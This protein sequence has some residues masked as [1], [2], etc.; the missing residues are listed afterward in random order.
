VALQ[1]AELLVFAGAGVSLSMPAGLPV[2]D[3]IRDEILHQLGLDSYVQPPGGA[4]DGRAAVAA[5]LVPE[6]FML[7]LS[8]AGVDVQKWLEMVL[9]AGQPNA[10]HRVLAQLTAA[11]ARVWTVNFD[12]LI[13]KAAGGR[14]ERIAWPNDPSA[15]APLMK[16]HGSVGGKLIVTAAQ[17]L[18]GL[19]ATWLEQ[20]RAD[21]DGRTVIFIGYRGR[22]LDFQPVWDDVLRS[23]ARVLWFDKWA[24]GRPV[25]ATRKRLMLRRVDARGDLR[26]PCPA[27]FPAGVSKG[28]LPNPSWDFIDWCRRRE[29]GDVGPEL[30]R[31]LFDHTPMVSYPSLPGTTQWATPSVQGLLGDYAAARRRYL[32]LALRPG[33][34]REA[35]GSLAA[36][37]INH[38]GQRVAMLL[39][40]SGLLPQISG[41]R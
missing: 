40:V 34:N 26:F 38:G 35:S 13:E 1:A 33:S 3:W 6:P 32:N 17:V 2:F 20:L 37:M 9:S 41:S 28:A 39:A 24:D 36:S 4:L 19:D 11:G 18:A 21:V 7:E 30:V 10:V 14:L 16:P 5:G 23:A 27:P 15:G 22:D 29:F 12:T 31:Q 25:E 8:R